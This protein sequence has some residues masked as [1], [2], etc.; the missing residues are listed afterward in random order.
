MARKTGKK[1][2]TEDEVLRSLSKKNDSR[3]FPN[4]RMIEV[5]SDT[6]VNKKGDIVPNPAKRF[7]LGNNSWSKIDF[8]VKYRNYSLVRVG[9]F[10]KN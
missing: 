6:V 3:L 8:L 9:V 4:R 7:D 10:S 1:T 2:Y 5:L